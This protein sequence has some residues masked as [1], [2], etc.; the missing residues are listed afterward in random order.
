MDTEQLAAFVV[1]TQLMANHS[2]LKENCIVAVG[3]TIL[4]DGEWKV[5]MH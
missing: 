5:V 3:Q 2:R 1:T 4:S